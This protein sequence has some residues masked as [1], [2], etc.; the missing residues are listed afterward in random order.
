MEGR[1]HHTKYVKDLGSLTDKE[2]TQVQEVAL[3]R[4]KEL[5]K[6]S[7]S[8]DAFVANLKRGKSFVLSPAL[9]ASAQARIKAV[10]LGQEF[11]KK[12]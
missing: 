9:Q 4:L 6:R 11:R 1:E 5:L 3:G 12:K 2:K 7:P 8:P 10:K